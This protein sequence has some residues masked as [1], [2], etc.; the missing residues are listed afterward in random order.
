MDDFEDRAWNI[1]ENLKQDCSEW[2]QSNEDLLFLA[3]IRGMEAGLDHS[4]NLLR[5]ERPD[6]DSITDGL[7]TQ[8]VLR[9]LLQLPEQDDTEDG[10]GCPCG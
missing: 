3:V 1:V 9:A 6:F 4:A 5:L 8:T 7:G 10:D 2:Q